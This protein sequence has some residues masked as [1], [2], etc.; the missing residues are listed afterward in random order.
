[1][2]DGH[3]YN[4]DYAGLD[5]EHQRC[6]HILRDGSVCGW[7]PEKH[8]YRPSTAKREFIKV[9]PTDVKLPHLDP[10]V[11]TINAMT[12]KILDYDCGRDID[13]ATVGKS[14]PKP[15]MVNHPPH[16]AAVEGIPF[17]CITLSRRFTFDV[18]NAIKYIWRTDRKNGR[19]DVEKARWY[20]KDAIDTDDLIHVDLRPR[21]VDR[22]NELLKLVAQAQTES[23]RSWFFHALWR[24]SLE[25]SL[26]A[27]DDLL[28]T[29]PS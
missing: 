15:D 23:A 12:G 26:Q 24:G 7:A 16:Y 2:I 1:M 13:L 17:E 6:Q 10:C 3:V 18:G 20:I 9:E 27:L 29:W 4:T 5:Q 14:K 22:T 21:C 25:E 8:M 11:C 19:E 28:D